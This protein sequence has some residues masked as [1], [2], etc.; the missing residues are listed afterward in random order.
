MDANDTQ[1]QKRQR[2][3]TREQTLQDQMEEFFVGNP[4]FCVAD[5]IT[6]EYSLF[7]AA[8]SVDVYYH[9]HHEDIR[10]DVLTE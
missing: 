6:Y 7:R 2:T 1:K 9:L 3:K 8:C 5:R 4:V 10:V